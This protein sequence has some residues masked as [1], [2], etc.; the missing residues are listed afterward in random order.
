MGQ[1]TGSVEGIG[2]LA[3]LAV[4]CV[5]MPQKVPGICGLR[6]YCDALTEKVEV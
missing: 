4:E 3:P 5:R 6:F 1:L 2:G